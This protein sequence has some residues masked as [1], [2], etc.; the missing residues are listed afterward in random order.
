MIAKTTFHRY[1]KD[2][3]LNHDG[4]LSY[5]TTKGYVVRKDGVRQNY[6]ICKDEINNLW[7]VYPFE[8]F[9]N[10]ELLFAEDTLKEVKEKLTLDI[11]QLVV[12]CERI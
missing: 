8:N 3:V 9:E 2:W 1:T 10:S 7:E 4:Y 11:T 5:E 6:F 12:T